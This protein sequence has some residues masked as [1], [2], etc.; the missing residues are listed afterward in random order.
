MLPVGGLQLNESDLCHETPLGSFPN[1]AV[2]PISMHFSGSEMMSLNTL[3]RT[4]GGEQKSFGTERQFLMMYQSGSG[5]VLAS[6]AGLP[7]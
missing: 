3:H 4:L 7:D 2:S 5:F 6:R 1:T